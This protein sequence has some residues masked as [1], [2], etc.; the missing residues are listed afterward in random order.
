MASMRVDDMHSWHAPRPRQ[1]MVPAAQP[2]Q[3]RSESRCPKPHLMPRGE[4]HVLQHIDLAD[5]AIFTTSSVKTTPRVGARPSTRSSPKIA[6]STTPAGAS[7][8][9]ATRSIASQARSG[10]LILTFDISQSRNPR[11][12]AMAGG[13]SGYRAALVRRQL[14]PG[15]TSLLPGTAGLPPFLSFSISYPELD[16]A[17]SY[18]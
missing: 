7:T 1:A 16:S 2:Q 3:S 17:M 6:C 13:S 5:P 18:A 10:L 12:W 8:V 9:A 14:T 11:N 15:L 4:S